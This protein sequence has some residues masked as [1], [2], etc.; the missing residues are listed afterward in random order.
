MNAWIS[1]A[2]TRA[3]SG[4]SQEP[5]RS[6]QA[7]EIQATGPVINAP[8]VE[9]PQITWIGPYPRNARQAT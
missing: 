4:L 7:P 9:A 5:G 3:R 2:R 1:A 8:T 6:T